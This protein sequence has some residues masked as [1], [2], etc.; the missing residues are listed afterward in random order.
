MAKEQDMYKGELGYTQGFIRLVRNKISQ[1]TKVTY[2][3]Y[4][5]KVSDI[6]RFRAPK[7]TTLD[8][9]TVPVADRIKH[10]VGYIFSTDEVTGEMTPKKRLNYTPPN[11]QRNARPNVPTDGS[12]APPLTAYGCPIRGNYDVLNPEW[13]PDILWN[14]ACEVAIALYKTYI[15]PK[16][17]HM[18][19]GIGEFDIKG[20][21]NSLFGKAK[22]D[23]M[24][25]CAI[26]YKKIEA[27]EVDRN[28]FNEEGAQWYQRMLELYDAMK[29][30]E[31]IDNTPLAKMREEVF[32]K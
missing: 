14:E 24:K 15:P 29:S 32:V 22:S 28:T 31:P 7:S 1:L 11:A 23:P 19:I 17:E 3:T 21:E 12:T 2:K 4:S 20:L 10:G 30:L 8:A 13:I 26:L 27:L 18:P 9:E 5:M 6:Y 25:F 16:H